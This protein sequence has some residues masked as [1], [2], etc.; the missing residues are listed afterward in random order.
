M[1]ER[2]QR[3]TARANQPRVDFEDAPEESQAGDPGAVVRGEVHAAEDPADESDDESDD[4]RE[5]DEAEADPLFAV[6][7][8]TPDHAEG[9]KRNR[10]VGQDVHGS[11]GDVESDEVDAVA[12]D[13]LVP[14]LLQRV[15]A[16]DFSDHVA[17]KVGGRDGH[18]GPADVF[19]TPRDGE[20][21]MIGH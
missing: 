17:D 5:E 18:G 10:E 7:F 14:E 13:V 16:S 20:D 4:R 9:E 2:L 3:Q 12:R 6:H 1:K 19:E 11:V 15:A 8:E 21:A